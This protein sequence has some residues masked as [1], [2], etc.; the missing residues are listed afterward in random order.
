VYEPWGCSVAFRS[1]TLLILPVEKVGHVPGSWRHEPGHVSAKFS[2][3]PPKP[4]HAAVYVGR[5]HGWNVSY[6]PLTVEL[7]GRPL[8]Q[9]NINTY[10]RIE[11]LPE[12]YKLA[13]ADTYLKDYLRRTACATD[14][15][16]GGK[17]LLR[18]ADPLCR[19]FTT[20]RRDH[21]EER[22]SDA[23]RGRVVDARND[24]PSEIAPLSYVPPEANFVGS[25]TVR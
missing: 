4:G 6:I 18:V 7:D 21:W 15:G 9:L 5:L 3:L 10:T 12:T 23:D 14:E 11:L 19:E 25:T 13:A 16:R 1:I 24:A 22:H 17:I 20:G 2:A 8:P